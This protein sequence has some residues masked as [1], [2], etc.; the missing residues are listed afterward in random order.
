VQLFLP[1]IWYQ[2]QSHEFDSRGQLF[3]ERLLQV[4]QLSC[5]GGQMGQVTIQ[6]WDS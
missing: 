1:H 2:S 4:A 6:K 5:G 3:S